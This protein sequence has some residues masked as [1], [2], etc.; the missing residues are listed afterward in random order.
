MTQT[1]SNVVLPGPCLVYIAPYSSS[2]LE[3]A[4]TSSI[5]KG[6]AWGGNWVE[7]GYTQGGVVGTPS[8]DFVSPDLDQVNAPIV[9]FITKQGLEVTFAAAE[10]TLTN[11]K[12][13]L[14]YGTLTTGSTESTLGVSGRDGLPTYY[15]I[16]F[17]CLANGLG[18]TRY[19]RLIVWKALPAGDIELK[20]DKG[21]PMVVAY[22]F[23]A[24]F[25]SQAASGENL[26]KLI[27]RQVA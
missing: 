1:A 14:G 10:A 9:D 6:S 17:E 3:A 18:S 20:A 8:T 16:G 5:A 23:S 13:A 24:R 21:E 11:I 15:T 7:I 19:R 26:F 25:E 4:P 22:K 2:S 27:D 12:Q